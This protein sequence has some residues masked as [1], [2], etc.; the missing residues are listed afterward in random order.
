MHVKPLWKYANKGLLAI[1][2]L[3]IVFSVTSIVYLAYT[4]TYV[5]SLLNE[6]SPAIGSAFVLQDL[7]MH[8]HAH[9]SNIRGYA[10]SGDAKMIADNATVQTR[11]DRDLQTIERNQQLKMTGEQRADVA[12]MSRQILAANKHILTLRQ[13]GGED[14]ARQAA[15]ETV[16]RNT[17]IATQLQ[18]QVNDIASARLQGIGPSLQRSEANI[19]RSLFV[20][21]ALALFVV[22]TCGAVI[23]YFQRAILRER[24]LD[25]TKS[26]FLSLASH[27]LRTPATNVKQYVALILDGYMG[28]ITDQQRHALEIAYRNNDAEISI[29]NNLLDVAK[30]D[31]N[32]IQLT[33]T[34]VNIVKLA[35]QVVENHQKQAAERDQTLSLLGEAE[36]VAAVDADYIKGVIENLVDNALKYSRNS[37]SVTVKV[38]RHQDYI[39][40]AVKDQG[41]GI[42]KRDFGKLFNKFSRLDNEFSANSQGSGLG[43]YWVKQIVAL[44]GGKIKMSSREGKGSTFTVFLPIK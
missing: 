30:L 21:G 1:L 7:M 9:E 39:T 5:R 18:R 8:V 13:T 38:L 14:A 40:L 29:M 32:K 31:L 20:A 41:L 36:V 24:A 43:L 37:T 10:L 23:W 42:R 3:L 4:L 2:S 44:H 35:S 11:I 25:N 27:Q 15:T 17:A 19:R 16:V 28:E 34:S 6:S 12:V 33:K 22:A 26:E